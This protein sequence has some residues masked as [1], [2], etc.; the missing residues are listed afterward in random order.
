MTVVETGEFLRAAAAFLGEAAR[1]EFI[2]FIA[3]NPT[4]GE[5]IPGTG[6]VARE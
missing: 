4:A 5:I 6:E 3:A 2:N 1:M